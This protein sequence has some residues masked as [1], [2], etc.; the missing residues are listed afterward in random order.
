M[1]QPDHTVQH[2]REMYPPKTLDSVW[3]VGIAGQY[4][5]A[6]IVTA[7]PKIA[8]SPQNVA[9][10]LESGLTVFFLK[11]FAALDLMDQAPK[12]LSVWPQI[13]KAAAHAPPGSGFYITIQGKL[14]P[15]RL[16]GR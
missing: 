10:W 8:K 3:L 1:L 16:S 14:E 12:L 15:V 7:D 2:L 5:D 4:P 6:I 11:A 9:A 13:V